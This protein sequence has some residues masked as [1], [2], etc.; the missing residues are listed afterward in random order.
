M[1]RLRDEAEALAKALVFGVCDVAEV[2]AWADAQILREC[3]PPE[4]LCEVSLAHD[5][6]PEDVARL[7]REWPG[8][9]DESEVGHL[10]VTL[11]NDRLK[12]DTGRAEGIALALYRMAFTEKI[13]DPGLRDI[14]RWASDALHLAEV[15]SW[16]ET[17]KQVVSEMTAA[18]DRVA[19][20][21]PMTWS[22]AFTDLKPD[23]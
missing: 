13:E 17:R 8:T 5:R 22:F 11:L 4:A 21:S 7:L 23:L 9:P 18:L 3:S 15:E 12:R 19:A 1:S 2:I 20:R 10:L 14:A 16:P 6:Y